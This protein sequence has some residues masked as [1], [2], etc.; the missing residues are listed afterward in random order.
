MFSSGVASFLAAARVAATHGTDQ[1][2][3]VFTDVKGDNPSEHAG[4]DLDNYRFLA[5]TA[6][7]VYGDTSYQLPGGQLTRNSLRASVAHL[8]GLHWIVST[9]DIWAV[10][11]RRRRI[12]SG[13]VAN[14]S[15]ELKQKPA[16]AWLAA[17]CPDTERTSVYV[18]LDWTEDHRNAAVD[19]A[20][21]PYRVCYPMQARPLIAKSDMLVECRQ[22][23]VEPPRLY[24][25]GWAH[26][27]C[28]GFCVKAGA[29]TFGL[30]LR[31]NPARYAYHE[32]Q[33]ERTRQYLGKDVAVL[34]ET[35]RGHTTPVT[36][37]RFRERIEA[38]GELFD[39]FD[40]GGCGCFV[41]EAVPT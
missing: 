17:H 18:G 10:F 19:R 26:A 34:N 9:E 22:R 4:E 11:R 14:C 16:H 27:N 40:V 35:V 39:S 41:D 24:R 1:L 5:Q 13:F 12:G 37:R 6:A 31:E 2:A 30:L 20:Y 7:I 21:A 8:P 28:G 33:E 36:L 29:A 38:Q 15:Q 23:G 32:E 25:A 3:L